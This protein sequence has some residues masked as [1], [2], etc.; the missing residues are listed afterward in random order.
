[1]SKENKIKRL[2]NPFALV[3]DDNPTH[4][5]LII[6]AL[7]ESDYDWEIEEFDGSYTFDNVLIWVLKTLRKSRNFSLTCLHLDLSWISEEEKK[8]DG[9]KE[10]K[11]DEYI[12]LLLCPES[13]NARLAD[14]H[15]PDGLL[16]IKELAQRIVDNFAIVAISTFGAD[17]LKVIA[18][19]HG[20]DYTVQKFPNLRKFF[21]DDEQNQEVLENMFRAELNSSLHETYMSLHKAGAIEIPNRGV[22]AL[23]FDLAKANADKVQHC[24][25]LLGHI[26]RHDPNQTLELDYDSL[27]KHL[28][29]FWEWLDEHFWYSQ[30]QFII[31]AVSSD[32]RHIS[33]RPNYKFGKSTLELMDAKASLFGTMEPIVI[34]GDSEGT[35]EKL[36]EEIHWRSNCSGPLVVAH[37][38]GR[39]ESALDEELFS[40]TGKCAL[41]RGGTLFVDRIEDASSEIQ[42]KLERLVT[43]GDFETSDGRTLQSDSRI[44]LSSFERDL[45]RLVVE[46]TFNEGLLMAIRPKAIRLRPLQERSEEIP[47]IAEE[48]LAEISRKRGTKQVIRLDESGNDQIKSHIWRS[49]GELRSFLATVSANS[50]EAKIESSELKKALVPLKESNSKLGLENNRDFD[51][52]GGTLAEMATEYI[53]KTL[54]NSKSQAEAYRQLDISRTKM[55][56]FVK[57]HDYKGKIGSDLK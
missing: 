17:A 34:I 16:V 25:N 45:E 36:A 21:N 39:T 32:V 40:E 12:Q 13:A 56:A 9:I 23:D 5:N 7:K 46:S 41:A 37:C 14:H 29:S 42:R 53:K 4:R 1:M 6:R 30:K 31:S 54:R 15:I 48:I 3:A 44:L 19:R 50:S 49:V 51:F 24:R 47:M 11:V 2:A 18:T 10:R 38:H 35:N 20:A 57:E 52:F 8:I 22:V 33:S 55:S 28:N 26:S 27:S 43:N